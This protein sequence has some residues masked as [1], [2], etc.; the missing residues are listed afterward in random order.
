MKKMIHSSSFQFILMLAAPA[1]I[2]VLSLMLAIG[3]YEVELFYDYFR[4][5]LI[6]LLNYL[7]V[8]LIYILLYA[9]LN[10]HALAY[11]IAGLVVLLFTAADFYMFSLRS[12]PL[13]ASDLLMAKAGLS[14]VGEYKLVINKRIV[15]CVAVLIFGSVFLALLFRG[16]LGGVSRLILAFAVILSLFPLWRFV[17]SSD[18]LY[19]SPRIA[20]QHVVSGWIQQ[21]YAGKGFLY[22]FIYSFSGEDDSYPS[23]Y[24]DARCADI[25]SAF[26]SSSIPAEKRVNLIVLQME[27]FN[28]I[29]SLGLKGIRE[30]VYSVYDE[31]KQASY[32]APL[33]VNV[34]G[35]G[36][37]D[38]EHCVLTGDSAY[39]FVSS[40]V[41]SFVSY[42]AENGYLTTGNHPNTGGFYDR[43]NVNADLGFSEYFFNEEL[44]SS[45]TEDL[46]PNSWYSDCVL[47]PAILSRF[48]ELSSTGSPVFSFNVSMQGHSPYESEFLVSDEDF[49]SREV[50]PACS[51]YAFNVISN[52]LYS[53]YDTQQQL[54]SFMSALSEMEEPVVVVLYGDHRPWLGDGASAAKEL[55]VNMNPSDEPGFMNYYSTEFLVWANDAAKRVTGDVYS[56]RGQAISA[57]YLF[58]SVFDLLGWEG[59]SY[60]AYLNECRSTLPVVTSNGYYIFN[61][62][63]VIP[64]ACP[65][66]LKSQIDELSAVQKYVRSH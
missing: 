26:P 1:V 27:A 59:S 64:S 19:Y 12:E 50:Y 34:Y 57:G 46:Q 23:G 14:M 66:V 45:L 63:F 56:G 60:C 17:Y 24:D 5:P 28:D 9:A 39:R 15:L 35:G 58:P 10:N 53:V 33:V 49:F 38:T 6:F 7:P 11:F 16:K 52:Y 4:L 43:R 2:T 31:L 22:P 65:E 30:D 8:L 62:E 18:D 51:D 37:I 36:T 42:L 32:S 20:S 3:M 13:T 44:Y 40:P 48:K 55:G 29:R 54:A 47:F 61:N 41:S 25:L 21:E